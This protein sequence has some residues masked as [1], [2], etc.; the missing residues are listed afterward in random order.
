MIKSRKS[1]PQ[2]ITDLEKKK[3]EHL[4]G[5]VDSTHHRETMGKEK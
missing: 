5:S 2:D 4:P 1:R 3:K